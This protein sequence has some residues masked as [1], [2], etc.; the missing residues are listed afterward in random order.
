MGRGRIVGVGLVGA[1]ALFG[2]GVDD[3]PEETTTTTTAAPDETSGDDGS[4]DDDATA[5]EDATPEE[6]AAEQG[7]FPDLDALGDGAGRVPSPD[8]AL[9]PE[10][11]RD[12]LVAAGYDCGEIED[13]E[14]GPD[15]ADLGIGP[16]ATFGCEGGDGPI[17]TIIAADEDEIG[18]L[19][20]L[21]EGAACGF[22]PDLV[23]TG[24]GRWLTGPLGESDTA[25]VTAAAE[26]L[27]TELLPFDCEGLGGPTDQPQ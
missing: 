24:E 14:I 25:A 8:A 26:V 20:V 11:A 4:T 21:V 16:T 3:E 17:E 6:E 19:F 18:R 1:L 27:G 15:E 10:A 7:L 2:C 5:E 13:Y 23:L 22:E 12:R 9:S